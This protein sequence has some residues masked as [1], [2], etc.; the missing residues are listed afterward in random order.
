[1]YTFTLLL[2]HMHVIFSWMLWHYMN[3]T[4]IIFYIIKYTYINVQSN[5]VISNKMGSR[6][7]LLRY[8]KVWDIK[9]KMHRNVVETFNTLRHIHCIRNI[10]VQD[11]E[12][13]LYLC[14]AGENELWNIL[15]KWCTCLFCF[16]SPLLG[17]TNPYKFR[18]CMKIL[19]TMILDGNY[20]SINPNDVPNLFNSSEEADYEIR[21][22]STPE[23]D[24]QV[25][26]KLRDQRKN[27]E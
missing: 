21:A 10:D 17:I 2:S 14:L 15:L 9:V 23:K 3:R 19:K 7:K 6:K 24:A 18:E 5:L 4:Y 26:K 16:V 25:L 13:Q 27:Q 20:S 11:N 12:I 8:P 1:M 22:S